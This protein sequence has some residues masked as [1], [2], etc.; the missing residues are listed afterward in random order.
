MCFYYSSSFYILLCLLQK[1]RTRS[2]LQIKEPDKEMFVCFFAWNYKCTKCLL[3]YHCSVK[4]WLLVLFHPPG[5]IDRNQLKRYLLSHSQFQRCVLNKYQFTVNSLAF[6][7]VFLLYSLQTFIHHSINKN[8]VRMFSVHTKT[9]TQISLCLSLIE[10]AEQ[11]E[12]QR[13]NP[14]PN[15]F[16]V[17]WQKSIKWYV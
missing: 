7:F 15:C 14:Q 1:Y 6:S 11:E 12:L 2:D 16:N 13:D 8:T 10:V 5:S 9:G 17:W 3:L 4:S